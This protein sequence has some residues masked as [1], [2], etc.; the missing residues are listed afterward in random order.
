MVKELGLSAPLTTNLNN[1]QDRPASPFTSCSHNGLLS[2][3][4]CFI[5]PSPSRS[6]DCLFTNRFSESYV[7]V[8]CHPFPIRHD[9][10]IVFSQ[11]AS[12]HNLEL[13]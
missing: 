10:V 2:S 4:L 12:T 9:L 11:T 13:A 7:P 3:Y 1:R 6:F 5:L 8:S